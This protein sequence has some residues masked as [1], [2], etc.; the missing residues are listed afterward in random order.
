MPTIIGVLQGSASLPQLI[1]RSVVPV[2]TDYLE[3]KSYLRWDF[4]HSCAYCTMSESEALAIRFTIDHYEP[5]SLRAD[6]KTEYSNLMYA[7]GEC[8]LRKGDL[9]P[10]PAARAGGFRF[11]RPDHDWYPEHFELQVAVDGIRLISKTKIGELTIDGC[12]LNRLALRRLREI[13]QQLDECQ[14]FVAH[15]ILA[16]QNFQIDQLPKHIRGQALRAIKTNVDMVETIES[17]VDEVLRACGKSPLIDSEPGVE[18]RTAERA[19]RMG[20]L[21]SLYPGTWRAFRKKNAAG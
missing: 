16:L 10:P 14:K 19:K 11:F 20:R 5:V 9:S 21:K 13:R 6:L 1:T 8:N 15:G 12:D 17:D 7:C 4:Y 3:Y 18:L 2:F